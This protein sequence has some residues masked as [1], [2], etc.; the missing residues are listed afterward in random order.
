[1][2]EF[3]KEAMFR[4]FGKHRGSKQAYLR[5][6]RKSAFSSR[7]RDSYHD[8]H[9]RGTFETLEPRWVLDSVLSNLATD[10]SAIVVSSQQI[11]T[12]TDAATAGASK[13][14]E[15][16]DRGVVAINQGSGKV[17]VSWR[18]LGT[19]PS[20]V[21]FNLYRSTNGAAAVKLNS[22]PITTTTDYVD[23]G[24]NTALSNAYFIRP[25]VDGVEQ[26]ASPSFTLAASA[27]VL[28]YLSIPLNIPAGVTT[29]DGVTCTYSANDC[30][31]GD[32]DGD[33]QYEIV[34]KWDPSNSQDNAN[35]GYTGNVYID[36]YKLNGTQLWRID[37]GK[38][39]RAGA[40]YTQ[41]VVYDLDGD[42]RAEIALKTAPG[43]KDGTGANVLLSGDNANADYR[44]SSGYILTG[45]EY[46]T[47]FDGTTGRA[48]ATT[49]YLPARGSV[50]D[51]GDNY[52]NRVDRFLA[53]VAYLDGTRPSLV[54]CRAYYGPRSGYAAKNI[55]GAWNYRNG[56]LTHLWQFEAAT[57]ID[58]NINSAYVGQGFHTLGI[59]DVD[60]DGKDEV[61]YGAAVID[62]S[63]SPVYTTGLGHGDAMDVGDFDPNR[64]GLEIY[65]VHESANASDGVEFHNAATGTI[66]W[67]IGTTGDTGRGR[68]DNIIA[69]TVGAEMWS[70]ANSNL[71]DVNGNVVGSAPSSDN[72]L[73]WWDAD[74][75]RELED[76]TSITK[77]SLSGTTTLLTASGCSSNNST[78]STPC[79][80]ADILGDWREEV[81]WRTSD[82]S[83]LRIYTTTTPEST[84][85]GFR[86]YTL[87]DDLQYRESIVWQNTAY[88]QPSHTSFYL[89][90]G[91][92]APP[93]ANIYTVQ[94]TP[95]PPAVPAN[96]AATVITPSRINVT[97]SASSGATMYRIKRCLSATGVFN[98]IGFATS[99]TTYSDTNVTV[100]G[101]YYYIVTAISSSGESSDSPVVVGSITGLPAPTNLSATLYSTT[102]VRLSWTAS[103]GATSYI[104]RR[105]T[106]SGGPY[107]TIA[108][109][110]TTTSYSDTTV[111]IGP[112]YYY[113]VAAVSAT[114]GSANSNEAAITTPLPSP[115]ISQNIGSVTTPGYTVYSSGTF[116]VTGA[117][118]GIQFVNQGLIGDCT[119]IAKL[120]SL[121]TTSGS[122]GIMIRNSLAS[123]SRYVNLVATSDS[124][125][126][127]FFN[128]QTS[129]GGSSN[130]KYDYCATPIW[131]QL[132]RVGST[133]TGYWST[134]G[135]TWN[136][137]THNGNSQVTVSMNTLTYGGM[138]ASSGSSNSIDTAVFSSISV[139]SAN[140]APTVA[141]AASASP[142]PVTGTT[143]AL[144]VLGD[145]DGG[146]TN[147]KYTW[148]TTGTPPAAVTF[149][150]NGTNA[151]KSTIATFTKAG[152]YNLQA[153][154]MD[155]GGLTVTSSV[156]VT[157]NQTLT[158]VG[159]SP[160]TASL[161]AG[162]TRQFTATAYDQFGSALSTQPTF[163]WSA[164]NGSITSDGLYTAPVT[165][166]SATVTAS[167]GGK[168]GAAAVTLV[169]TVA[170]RKIFYN[171]SKFDAHAGYPSG[172]LA[173]NLYDDNAIA[174]D[175]SALLPGQT[176]T[177]ANFTSYS[178][179]I[180]G[181][182]IDIQNLAGTP[183]VS[184]YAQ[185]FTFKVGSD[186]TNWS[187]AAAP[188]AIDVRTGAGVNNSYRVTIIWTDNAIQNQWLQ[189]T[190]LAGS[191]TGLAANDVF[192][193][194]N[195]VGESGND[196]VVTVADEDAAI[197]NRTGFTLAAVSNNYDYN[198]DRQVSAADALIARQTYSGSQAT[199]Q[200]IAAPVS[201]PPASEESIQPVGD[202]VSNTADASSSA[203]TETLLAGTVEILL[204]APAETS[205][206]SGDVLLSA[207]SSDAA[208]AT[209]ASTGTATADLPLESVLLASSAVAVE[210]APPASSLAVGAVDT[211]ELTSA[212]CGP[213][214]EHVLTHNKVVSSYLPFDLAQT[215]QPFRRLLNSIKPQELSVIQSPAAHSTQL[216]AMWKALEQRHSGV[217]AARLHDAI[218]GWEASGIGD[219]SEISP[220]AA[221]LIDDL[222]GIIMKARG[223][224]PSKPAKTA[225]D[226][227][228]A[229]SQF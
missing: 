31:V 223:S 98:T 169:A 168:S 75:S 87:M 200:M 148:A 89:G 212:S 101:T 13:Q 133:F 44:N 97:W 195:L 132:T 108:T 57:G 184:N 194:G 193:F 61:V 156:A 90:Y 63:G 36:A 86:I 56:T 118:G 111:Q 178:R 24:A 189:V 64:S 62:D 224:K 33:G 100:G 107:T 202:S 160:S 88:N 203:A 29:P 35:S 174:T 92:S 47:V 126:H 179:G 48:L 228:L 8:G 55:V 109:G 93:T 114:N 157:V 105:G 82:S 106:A 159:L 177:F 79:L 164:T 172:D 27:P 20:T 42:G 113:V 201:S 25:V 72:F 11:Q 120:D 59:A 167:S 180:N 1:L 76:G 91:M 165:G 181:V 225:L 30:S 147:L 131:L 26:A 103:A 146:E 39:I 23:T 220:A 161:T 192:Y 66:Y 188:T 143:T 54:E 71:Y 6:R 60:S 190:S 186:G 130:Y 22:S 144:S 197:G 141:T 154:I 217:D 207:S 9:G 221:S 34:V 213:V 15:N 137:L 222:T 149:S 185:F 140:T 139:T 122:G 166:T 150:A 81:I 229:A 68:C 94:F 104:V 135:S 210:A 45:P 49:S 10:P 17:Y 175:K 83:A 204:A 127:I 124:S 187:S 21:A 102:Q 16:L 162:N 119:I 138:I 78:K 96:V 214:A 50:S 125:D 43:T 32:L 151:A 163:T 199:L 116:S 128:Y 123:N 219:G 226:D 171:N 46:L 53:G 7:S 85:T 69:G 77:Y 117:V 67:G 196:A 218:L 152:T 70:S 73:V 80:V 134:D 158:S 136:L 112:T 19:D 155:S 2:I 65:Q 4:F 74:L 14:M 227:F 142:S 115:W 84:S 121:S 182:M 3:R 12:L 215:S 170:G 129:D 40:H 110:V 176:A 206:A 153:T 205:P 173:A 145:D 5:G 198:R 51:W 191:S 211:R 99:G 28:P 216:D 18:L 52:G 209:F 37:L 208:A 183:T 41:M 95:S 58:G 38:N